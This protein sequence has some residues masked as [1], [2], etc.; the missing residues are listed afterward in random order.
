MTHPSQSDAEWGY[1]MVSFDE[2]EHDRVYWDQDGELVCSW[3]SVPLALIPSFNAEID[4]A[5][6]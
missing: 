5:A 2:C 1:E 6:G 3:C 4:E